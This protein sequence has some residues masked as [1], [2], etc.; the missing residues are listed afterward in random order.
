MACASC[1]V[2]WR[3]PWQSPAMSAS[4]YSV[5]TNCLDGR[6]ID[7]K[8]D[9]NIRGSGNVAMSALGTGVA[10]LFSQ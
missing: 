1:F 6:E 7:M 10:V 2:A 8:A 5:N 3:P 4:Q 9:V